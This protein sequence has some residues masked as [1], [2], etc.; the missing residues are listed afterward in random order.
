MIYNYYNNSIIF[1]FQLST[2]AFKISYQKS[3]IPTKCELLQR[4]KDSRITKNANE[5]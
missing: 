5:N 3:N 1:K 2:H 4:V